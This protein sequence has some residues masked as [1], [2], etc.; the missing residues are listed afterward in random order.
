MDVY[1]E[2]LDNVTE[3]DASGIRPMRKKSVKATGEFSDASLDGCFIDAAHDYEN[4]KADIAAWLPKV[5]TGGFFGGH[6]IDAPGVLQAV[7]E[8][9]FE[10]EKVGRC[11]IKK[12]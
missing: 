1:A 11:W 4:C 5:K 2:F 12:P 9:G 6:D 10:W 8:A 3:S 7:M